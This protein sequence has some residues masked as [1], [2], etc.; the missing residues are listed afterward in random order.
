MKNERGI[1]L[2]VYTCQ[3]YFSRSFSHGEFINVFEIM[4]SF[5]LSSSVCV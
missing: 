3:V 5:S 4:L 1:K 2:Y